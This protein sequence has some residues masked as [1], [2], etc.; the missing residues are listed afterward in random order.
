MNHIWAGL[1]RVLE[2]LIDTYKIILLVSVVLSWVHADPSNGIVRFV[3]VLTEPLLGWV[4]RRLPLLVQGGID[5]S[6]LAIFLALIFLDEA[7]VG[8][9]YRLAGHKHG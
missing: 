7:L 2:Y 5:L 8:N 4:R 6:P 3:R 1:A 9:L